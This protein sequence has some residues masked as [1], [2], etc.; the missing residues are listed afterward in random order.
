MP[1]STIGFGFDAGAS[2]PQKSARRGR[3]QILS[4]IPCDL[5]VQAYCNLPGN[6][7]PWNAVRRFVHE[8]QGL[9]KRMYGNIRH[10]SVLR[11]EINNND[12][13]LNDVE[14]VNMRHI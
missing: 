14:Q 13:G 11:N 8:N 9:M 4:S 2:C 1:L 3:A 7:Y 6:L 10:I 12:I 5:R